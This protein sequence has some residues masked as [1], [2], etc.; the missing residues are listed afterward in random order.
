MRNDVQEKRLDRLE[1][2]VD[3]LEKSVQ[4]LRALKT[5]IQ[6]GLAELIPSARPRP[7]LKVVKGRGDDA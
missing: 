4:E 5:Q 3:R 1:L 2:R 7:A 6:D